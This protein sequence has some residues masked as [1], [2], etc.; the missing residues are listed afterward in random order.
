MSSEEPNLITYV[1]DWG[2]ETVFIGL[3]RLDGL[4]MDHL[5]FQ[6]GVELI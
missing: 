4:S 6:V 2:R 3:F 1:V 5:G